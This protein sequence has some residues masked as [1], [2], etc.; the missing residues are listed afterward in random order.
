M[1][2]HISSNYFLSGG[3]DRS[4]LNSILSFNRKEESWQPVGQMTVPRSDHAVE[5]IEDVSQLC[6]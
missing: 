5:L 2:F 4:Y 1:I 6:P 3:Y